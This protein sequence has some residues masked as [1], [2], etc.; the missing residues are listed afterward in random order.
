[1]KTRNP[2]GLG[3]I[4]GASQQ[5][6]ITKG[7]V[8]YSSSSSSPSPPAAFLAAALVFFLFTLPGRP[9]PKGLVREKSMCFCESTLTMKEG[10]FTTCLP[11]LICL[12]R[13]RTLAWWMDLAIPDLKTRV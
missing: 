2:Y 11:T 7:S 8:A 10:T 5:C 12:C 13:M 1:M 6:A 9:P 3:H 4:Q